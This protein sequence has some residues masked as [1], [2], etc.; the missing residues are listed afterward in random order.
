[1]STETGTGNKPD[2][3]P[4]ELERL[5]SDWDRQER[6]EPP[7]LLDQ[8]VLNAARRDLKPARRSKRLGWV[9]GF[10][11]AGIAVVALS[12]VLLQETP[13]SPLPTPLEMPAQEAPAEFRAEKGM[14]LSRSAKAVKKQEM[15][16][17]PTTAEPAADPAVRTAPAAASRPQPE[18][19]RDSVAGLRVNEEAQEELLESA[20]KA[21]PALA[22]EEWLEQIQRLH[23]RG[24]EEELARQL[25][26]F[27]S[28]YPD[29]PLPENL[30]D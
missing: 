18:V 5:Q 7:E 24:D 4:Q 8:A 20:G 14:P 15:S 13:Q 12:L 16:A 3:L 10:A 11:T 30:R 6:A 28:T 21:A 25:Q 1:M 22:P 27:R 26:A 2:G 29:Y 17:A 9:G 19:M 23:E